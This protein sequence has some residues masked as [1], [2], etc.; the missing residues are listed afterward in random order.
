MDLQSYFPMYTRSEN[1]RAVG[2]GD[3]FNNTCLILRWNK[4]VFV[5]YVLYVYD[6]VPLKAGV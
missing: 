5:V 6:K 4:Y 2:K 3:L 1:V